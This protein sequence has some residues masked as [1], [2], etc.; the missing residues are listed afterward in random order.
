MMLINKVFSFGY[1]CFHLVSRIYN[2]KC[3][4]FFSFYYNE[5]DDDFFI[6]FSF[7]NEVFWI[8]FSQMPL[9]IE[10]DNF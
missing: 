7:V 1:E 2:V 6:F 8:G 4:N 5:H 9:N 3:K 10:H